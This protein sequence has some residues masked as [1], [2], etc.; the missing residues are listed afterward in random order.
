MV[1]GGNPYSCIGVL[2]FIYSDIIIETRL[3]TTKLAPIL[4][5]MVE[6]VSK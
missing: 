3:K 2:V 5:V 4:R 1:P 6:G